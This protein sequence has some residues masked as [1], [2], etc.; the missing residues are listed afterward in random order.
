[1]TVA[2]IQHLQAKAD[3]RVD[4]DLLDKLTEGTPG[5]GDKLAAQVRAFEDQGYIT[6]E[7]KTLTTHLVFEHG[8]LIVNGKPFP[9]TRGQPQ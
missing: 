3:I 8:K 2:L 4:T 6:H 5:N 1:M 9:P 7:G